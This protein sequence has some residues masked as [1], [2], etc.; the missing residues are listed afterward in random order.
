MYFEECQ[1]HSKV[2]GRSMNFNV[3]GHAGRPILV[4]PAS[5]G[6]HNEYG[7][8]GMIMRMSSLDR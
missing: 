4:F 6:S 2:L 7:D 8:F 3:Y 1:L 5:G